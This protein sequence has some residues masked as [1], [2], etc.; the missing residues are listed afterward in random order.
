MYV[1]IFLPNQ[2]P[3]E[4]FLINA[5]L[6]G[7]IFMVLTEIH[8]YP[9][10]S[11]KGISLQSGLVERRG[12]QFDR[13]WMVVDKAGMFLS[14]R[15]HP[16]LALVSTKIDSEVLQVKAA[17]MQTLELP[18]KQKSDE[19]V[20]V[21]VHDDITKGV[22][23]GEEAG[24][25]F[26]NFLGVSCRVVFMPEKILRLVDTGY[27]RDG[28]IVSFADAFPLLLIS[29]ASLDDLNSKLAIP[30]PMNRFRPNIVI[31]GCDAF[32]EDKWKEIRVGETVFYVIK[33]CARCVTTTV[34]QSTG[35]QGKEPLVTLSKYRK[36]DGQVLFGQ[37]VIPEKRGMLRVGDIVEVI[38]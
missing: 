34:D 3:V 33:P 6:G 30:V 23:A 36:V 28:D 25:W 4:R 38:S 8:I 37:N 29:Q 21:Q 17:G 5:F 24:N 10:K 13:R 11:T 9:I 15:D 20:Q 19:R 32:D 35:V 26:S 27:A 22:Y 16:R 18:M 31:S 7:L 1:N 12:I 14:Q 2:P